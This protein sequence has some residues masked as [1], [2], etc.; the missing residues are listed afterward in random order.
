MKIKLVVTDIDGVWTDG[1][2][3]YSSNGEELKK[4]N[5]IDSGGV[6]LLKAMNI[7]LMVITGENSPATESRMKKLKI[8]NFIPGAKD[9]LD[10]VLSFCKEN[11]IDP[12]E[13]AY[14]GDD[15]NDLKLLQKAGLS[16]VPASSVDYVK[17]KAQWVLQKKGGEGVFREFVEK[18]LKEAGI[19][20]EA[21]NK[22][23]EK[24]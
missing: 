19:L 12:S 11:N 4:F 18:I 6:L 3:F 9:K 7:P 17:K 5:T 24:I 20:E 1:G 13:V 10:I 21:V 23:I 15:L 8:K 14:L 22:V 16:A 2:M